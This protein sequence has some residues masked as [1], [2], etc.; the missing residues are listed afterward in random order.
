MD[1]GDYLQSAFIQSFRQCR[2]GRETTI[3]RKKAVICR[4]EGRANTEKSTQE[5]MSN[6]ALFLLVSRSETE[7]PLGQSEQK[8]RHCVEQIGLKQIHIITVE[9]RRAFLRFREAKSRTTVRE[10]KTRPAKE[11][12]ASRKAAQTEAFSIIQNPLSKQGDFVLLCGAPDR[13]RTC[14]PLGNRT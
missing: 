14:T 3:L 2:L 7:L 9:Q 11:L 5:E 13:G 10:V 6:P 12:R 1:F 8:Q 4:K